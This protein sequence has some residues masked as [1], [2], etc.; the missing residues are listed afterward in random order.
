MALILMES[1]DLYG[2]ISRNWLLDSRWTRA[3]DTTTSILPSSGRRS[4]G[5]LQLVQN[6]ATTLGSYWQHLNLQIAQSTVIMGFAFYAPTG[7]ATPT[8]GFPVFLFQKGTTIATDVQFV[9]HRTSANALEIRATA[10]GTLLATSAD[11]VVTPTSWQYWEIKTVCHASSGSVIINIDG[12]EVINVSGVNTQNA[13]SG[14][15]NLIHFRNYSNAGGNC[16]IDDLYLCDETGD[17]PFNDFLGDVEVHGNKFT[18][19]ET[20]G[21]FDTNDTSH[22]GAI[23]DVGSGYEVKY[24]EGD[25]VGEKDSFGIVPASD[26]PG[27]YAVEVVANGHN[28]GGGTA[29]FKPYVNIDGTRYYGDEVT[30]SAGSSDKNSYIWLLNPKTGGSWSKLVLAA[31]EFGYE[32]TEL[33]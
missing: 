16:L 9:I 10:G 26:N 33:T 18:S 8:A 17:A 1:F 5:C 29:K 11:N 22:Y 30:S 21:D 12:V 6:N 27:V 7:A 3:S 32:V 14:A 28:S 19:D 25:A 4:G 20:D 15:I 24:I 23:D 2:Y 13:G 31:A